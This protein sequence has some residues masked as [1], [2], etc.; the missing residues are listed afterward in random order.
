[1][2]DELPLEDATQLFLVS[3]ILFLLIGSV[4]VIVQNHTSPRSTTW[5]DY[6]KNYSH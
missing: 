6:E 2:V 5:E 3:G 4:L 1:M